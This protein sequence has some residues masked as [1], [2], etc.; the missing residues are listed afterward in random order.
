MRIAD[1]KP[2]AA[3][4]AVACLLAAR[5]VPA[6]SGATPPRPRPAMAV[7]S[8]PP[9][10][11]MLPRT[12]P[13]FTPKQ[14]AAW[15]GKLSS[16]HAAI[17]RQAKRHL[18]T[19]GT[20]AVAPLKAALAGWT[21][22]QMRWD[23]RDLLGAIAEAKAL[24]GPLVTLKLAHA[25]L[26]I[27]LQRLCR[28][29]GFTAQFAGTQ[30]QWTTRRLGI[31]VERQPFWKVIQRMAYVT[32]ASPCGNDFYVPAGLLN[33][34]RHGT[35]ARHT[36]VYRKGALLLAVQASSGGETATFSAPSGQRTSGGFSVGVMGLWAP[37]SAA[38]EQVGPVQFTQALDNRGRSLLAS[39]VSQYCYQSNS[40]DEFSFAPRL[41][42][43]SPHATKLA[44]LAG[45]IP[46]ALDITPRIRRVSNLDSGKATLNLHGLHVA[47]G[48]P[49]D[50]VIDPLNPR[51]G[52]CHLRVS[53]W[54]TADAL[55][56]PT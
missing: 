22:P 21:T 20:A 33:F 48:K 8:R 24:R 53:V 32:G 40:H 37:G 54:A 4:V 9:A 31:H 50:V 47:I 43:P 13:V 14:I 29:A 46:M 23:M 52:R 10:I 28:Q 41:H 30:L 7:A 6:V 34:C 44:V 2:W 16:P 39:T 5:P 36:P 55:Q 17:R 51:I 56:S 25:P 27:I 35:L 49:T 15:I 3:I 45:E 12:Q 18:I 26:R 19:V 1:V 38:V 42:W 11:I